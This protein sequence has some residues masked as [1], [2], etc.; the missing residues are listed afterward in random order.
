MLAQLHTI[1]EWGRLPSEFGLC[2]PE[3]DLT[4]MMA[5][6]IGYGKME[7]YEYELA[8][9]KNRSKGRGRKFE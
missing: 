7:A 5:H 6:D 4:Y 9:K 3:Y 1:R 2:A 8:E